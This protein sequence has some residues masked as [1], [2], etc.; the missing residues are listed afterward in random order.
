MGEAAPGRLRTRGALAS[1]PTWL[2]FAVAFVVFALDQISKWV[3]KT[4]LSTWD[5][6]HVIPGFFNIVHA[7]N[8]GVAFGFLAA[9]SGAVRGIVLVGVAAAVLVYVT[10]LLW[11]GR[12]RENTLLT[13]A[14]ALVLGGAMGNLYDRLARGTVTDFIEVYAGDHYFPAFNVADSAISMGGALLVLDMLRSRGPKHGLEADDVSQAH[15][16]R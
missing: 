2:P 16:N 8:R 14:L 3:I 7:E 6:V 5:T 4:R 10:V 1:C 12:T 13:M 15:L 11:T 9:S